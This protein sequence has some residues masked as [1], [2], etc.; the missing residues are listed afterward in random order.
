MRNR[1]VSNKAYICPDCGATVPGDDMNAFKDGRGKDIGRPYRSDYIKSPC[2]HRNAS[3]Y[4]LGF[5]FVTDML[6]LEIALDTSKVNI[7]CDENP[8][9][10]RAARSLSES[11]RLQASQLLDV[12][13]TELNTGYRL[14]EKDQTAYVDIYLYDNLSSE[15]SIRQNCKAYDDLLENRSIY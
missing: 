6:V 1:G 11:L 8:W 15:G 5:D 14:R 4:S 9:I 3:N 12:E 2:T 10:I 13:F 7:S